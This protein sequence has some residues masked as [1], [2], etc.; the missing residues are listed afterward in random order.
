M[1]VYPAGIC[2]PNC[3]PQVVLGMFVGFSVIIVPL[4]IVKTTCAVRFSN[5]STT[6]T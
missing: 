2:I 4:S 5:N 1:F 6:H 3:V